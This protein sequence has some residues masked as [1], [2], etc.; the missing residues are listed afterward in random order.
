LVVLLLLPLRESMN[1][2]SLL[3]QRMFMP[4][5]DALGLLTTLGEARAFQWL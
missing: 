4:S 1:V 5:R 3:T 2:C